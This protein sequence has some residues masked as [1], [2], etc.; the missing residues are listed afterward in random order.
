MSH[1]VTCRHG[2][3]CLMDHA[4][5]RLDRA[6]RRAIDTHVAGCVRCQGFVRSYAA[7][8]PILRRAT[9]AVLPAAVA[10]SLRRRLLAARPGRLRT[11]RG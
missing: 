10:R 11:R 5:G 2:V 6:A 1:A 8:P 9:A 4:E 7:T 3:E